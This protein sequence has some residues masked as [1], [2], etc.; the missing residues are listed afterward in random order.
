MLRNIPGLKKELQ[1]S[2]N[3]MEFSMKWAI[4]IARICDN[5]PEIS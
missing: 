3:D 2:N 1:S 5:Q 4:G